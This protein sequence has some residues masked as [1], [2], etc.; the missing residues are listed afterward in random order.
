MMQKK[1]RNIIQSLHLKII[2]PIPVHLNQTNQ[3]G[4]VSQ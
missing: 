1:G 3:I 2:Q 4:G